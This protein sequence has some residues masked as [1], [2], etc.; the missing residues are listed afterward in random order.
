MRRVLL[1]CACASLIAGAALSGCGASQGSPRGTST[2]LGSQST[3]TI[4][5]VAASTAEGRPATSAATS[6]T[7]G[8]GAAAGSADE[9][10]GASV[11][12]TRTESAPAFVHGESSSG[13]LA[14]AIAVLRHAG[15]EPISTATYNPEDALRVLIGARPGVAEGHR[16]QAFFFL[17]S[18]YLGTDSSTPSGSIS[19]LGSGVDEVTLGYALYRPHD[20]PCCAS[21]GLAQV[22]FSLNDGTLRPDRPL[23]SLSARR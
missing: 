7:S 16:Q 13:A 21:G 17:D 22:R 23:P 3:T 18:R 11:S 10:G 15:Y 8:S 14:S 12:S 19:V 1:P 2:R 5:E 6:T 9:R 4:A 20:P